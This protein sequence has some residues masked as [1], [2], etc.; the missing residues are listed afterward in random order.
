MATGTSALK[1]S[2]TAS[3]KWDLTVAIISS[4]VDVFRESWV[5]YSR[6]QYAWAG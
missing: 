2:L 4:T 1:R 5:A 3:V 6:S